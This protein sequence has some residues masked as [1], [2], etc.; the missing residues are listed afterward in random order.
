VSEGVVPAYQGD[1]V[2]EAVYVPVSSSLP[3]STFAYLFLLRLFPFP[4][5]LSPSSLLHSFTDACALHVYVR[6]LESPDDLGGP[7]PE[8]APR[9]RAKKTIGT[10]TSAATTER[11]FAASSVSQAPPT[12][13]AAALTVWQSYPPSTF[14]S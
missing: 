5:H 6:R 8:N 13:T 14:E 9:K 2:A 7:P 10:L 12:Q 4:P 11:A 1:L 3:P